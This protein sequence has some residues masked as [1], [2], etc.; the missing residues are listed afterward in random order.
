MNPRNPRVA[1]SRAGPW[2]HGQHTCNTTPLR[3]ACP[4]S[5]PNDVHAR[6]TTTFVDGSRQREQRQ[7]NTP[8]STLPI[9]FTPSSPC[10]SAAASTK[11]LNDEPGCR[12]P[13]VARL[14]RATGSLPL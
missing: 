1:A 4:R 11:G 8:K 7:L 2:R 9:S 13:W 6:S 14:N 5:H 12:E 3:R 10:S